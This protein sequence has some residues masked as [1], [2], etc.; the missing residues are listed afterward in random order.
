[1]YLSYKCFLILAFAPRRMVVSC[2]AARPSVCTENLVP[3]SGISAVGPLDLSR[4][5]PLGPDATSRTA[6]SASLHR[7]DS[8]D[9]AEIEAPANRAGS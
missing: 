3:L 7:V 6:A 1:M 8:A 9:F 5:L 4:S 2:V